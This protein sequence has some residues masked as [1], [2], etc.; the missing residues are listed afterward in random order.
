MKIKW[1]GHSAFLLTSEGG[2]RILI[3]PYFRF[4]RY[5]MP[6]VESDIVAVTHNHFDHSRIQA[7][8]GDYLLVNEPK[9]YIGDDVRISGFKTFHD[10]V[11]GEKRGLNIL[12]RFQMDGL[13]I[14]HCGDLG[15]LISDE[16]VNEIGKVDILIIPVGGT[17]T[18]NA[19]EATQVMRQLKPT[20]TI[21]MHY[22]TKALS[23]VG[24]MF[25]KVDK[26]LQLS[27]QRTTEVKTLDI[28]KE[29]LS[30]YAGVVTMLYE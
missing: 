18:I 13:T 8:T 26:F 12:Y 11:N 1:F 10:K 27:G 23:V 4:I 22:R 30:E 6:I 16:Q 14:C 5:R 15:H 25:S 21:P 9:E 19:L 28:S 7:A 3:D 17:F 24:L 29:N 2:T 20:I